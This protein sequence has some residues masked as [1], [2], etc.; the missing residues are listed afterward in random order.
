MIKLSKL[1]KLAFG[2]IVILCFLMGGSIQ[3]FIGIPNIVYSLGVLSFLLVIYILYISVKK[4]VLLDRVVALFILLFFFIIISAIYNST[5]VI[6][7]LIYLIFVLVPLSCYLFFHINNKEE[8]LPKAT[9]SKLFLIIAL[10]QLPVMLIQNYGYDFII[11]FNRSNQSIA[12]FDFMF[13]TFFLKADHAL[14]F[15]LL[16]NIINIYTRTK[17]ASISSKLIILYLVLTIFFGESNVSKLLVLIFILYMVYTI[18]PKK[19]RIIGL[20]ALVF[21]IPISLVQLNKI[22]AFETE[23]YF[24][25]NQYNIKTSFRNYEIGI[26]KRPQVVIS[27]ATKIPL[28]F[29]GDGPYSYFDIIKGKF[30]LTKHFSQLIWVYADIGLFGLTLLILILYI[31]TLN[32]GLSITL[33]FLVFSFILVYAF[34]TTILSDLVIMITFMS[35]LKNKRR[36][37]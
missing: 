35:L 33:R 29:I 11:D 34:M 1:Y 25:K 27:Y 7:T 5:A 12:P 24:I 32:L 37:L 8:Y 20:V 2:I 4:K 31:L 28:K 3:F 26:A 16:F 30:A 36:T 13:G 17:A 15:F 21:L 14:G 22:K 10:V 23:V 9:I 18:V 19:I 6:K